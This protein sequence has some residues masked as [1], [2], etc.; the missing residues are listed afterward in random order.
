MQLMTFNYFLQHGVLSFDTDTGQLSIDYAAYPTAV[1]L[2]LQ[3]L[4]DI[5]YQGDKAASDGFVE[6]YSN[7]DDNLHGVVAA[8]RKAALKVR[9]WQVNYAV[10]GE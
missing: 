3:R 5:Q 2:L 7:W 9:Y 6:Q 8:R 1:R 4:L 10:L